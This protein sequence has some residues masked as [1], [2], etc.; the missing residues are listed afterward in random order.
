MAGL[1]FSLD[2]DTTA[3][4]NG[5]DR[6]NTTLRE[7]LGAVAAENWKF[8]P[9]SS[10]GIYR[11][12]LAA[13]S[14]ALK[15][16]IDRVDRK[17]LNKEYSD[18]GLYFEEDEYQSVVDIM[19]SEKKEER[20]RQSII[21]RGPQG[22]WNPFSSG[23]YVGAAKFGTGL[24]VSMADFINIGASFIPIVGQARFAQLAARTS[25]RTARLTRGVAEGAF[26]AALVEPIVYST[27]QRIQADYDLRDSFLNITFGSIL[28]GGLHVGVGKIRDINTARKFKK[29]REKVKQARTDLNIKS[30]EVEPELNLY[31]EYFPEN[32][33]LMLKLEKT[34]PRTR[35]LLLQKS[36]GELMSERPVDTSAVVN[37][38]PVLRSTPESTAVPEITPR[39]KPSFDEVELNTVEK[40]VE[41][42]TPIQK[43]S[44]IDL[45]SSQLDTLKA[46]QTELKLKFADETEVKKAKEELDEVNNKSKELDEVVTDFI[47]CRNGR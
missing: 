22:S 12:V 14:E 5:Y 1:G 27:A 43:D 25:L 33:E 6:Y 18:L 40:T 44:E 13:Q 4:K 20:R 3:Q 21:A 30:G 41:N 47:N 34:D 8:N 11:S 29:F 7:T 26:G 42:K 10:I 16:N 36:L 37:A 23:F 24:A 2:T 31:K 28:G 39:P 35:K 45:L 19:V 32:G 17:E 15:N 38:D 9:I 46:N